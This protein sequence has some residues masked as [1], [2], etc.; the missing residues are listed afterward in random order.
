MHPDVSKS[1]RSMEELGTTQFLKF[2]QER[3]VE[4]TESINKPLKR[5]NAY[6]YSN[7]PKAVVA[8]E[9]MTIAHLKHDSH[10]LFRALTAIT[11]SDRDVS[12]ESILQHENQPF[13]PS[14]SDNQ[15]NGRK[16]E[17]S[18]ILDVLLKI[19]GDAVPLLIPTFVTSYVLDGPAIVHMLKGST[20]KV[21]TFDEFFSLCFNPYIVNLLGNCEMVSVVFDIYLK[22]I[23]P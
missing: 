2:M 5:N 11:T 15:G 9:D 23:S 13:P 6:T 20:L 22:A 10:T 12:I 19:P 4:C 3:L 18:K 8:K 14:L 7:L 1:Y 17:K 16:T 21:K